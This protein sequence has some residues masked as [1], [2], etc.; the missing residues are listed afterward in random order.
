MSVLNQGGAFT[1][2]LLGTAVRRPTATIPQTATGTL[3]TVTGGRVL[4][5]G[6]V[7]EV[8]TILGAVGNLN[9]VHDPDGAGAVG[10]LCAATACGTDA[11]GTLYT[12]SGVAADLLSEQTVAGT[13]APTHVFALMGALAGKGIVL[14]A[15]ALGLKASASSTGSIK[16]DL[17]YVPLDEGA[18]V[19]AA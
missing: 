13:E 3:F 9:L 1:R 5:T 12:I 8:T 10:D 2:G 11:V 19:V 4:V 16:W 15:G 18:S 14:P 17:F 7:G 6:I